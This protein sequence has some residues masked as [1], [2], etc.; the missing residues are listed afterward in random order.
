MGHATDQRARTGCTVVLGPFRASVDVRGLASG[1]RQFDSLSPGHLAAQVDAILLTGGSAYGLA[2]ADGVARWMEE[3]GRGM[4][5][6]AGRIAI[7][8]TAVIYD[9]GIGRSDRRPDAEMGRAACE[10]ASRQSVPEGQIGVGSGASVGKLNGPARA[11]NGGVGSFTTRLEGYTIAA[12]AVVNAFGD[13]LDAGG[14]IVAGARDEAGEFL[15]TAACLRERPP[16]RFA[17]EPGTNTTLAVIATDLPLSRADL[18]VI[19]R[20]AMNAIVR[21]IS[22]A[23]TQFDGDLVFACSTAASL[24]EYTAGERLRF[25]LVAEWALARSIERAVMAG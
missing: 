4:E 1:T 25:G 14:Q 16:P 9:L 11:M 21:H 15:D 19:A 20:Q 24:K 12:L 18:Q 17:A 6:A 10:T 7:V 22:P 5:T 13:V 23:N 2:A 3:Q 8:P